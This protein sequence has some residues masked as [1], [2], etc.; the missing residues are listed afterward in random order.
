MIITSEGSYTERDDVQNIETLEFLTCSRCGR[1][2]KKK[3]GTLYGYDHGRYKDYFDKRFVFICNRCD[4]KG[5]DYNKL[6]CLC[7]I[8]I[9]IMIL[10][11]W[12][13]K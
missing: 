4:G 7:M 3:R 12:F 5:I 6:S 8:L 13:P 10:F 9:F 11:G 2:K 1:E